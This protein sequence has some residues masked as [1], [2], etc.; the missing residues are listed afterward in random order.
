[1]LKG[2]TF[3]HMIAAL[4]LLTEYYGNRENASDC[5]GKQDFR[6]K[7]ATGEISHG[8]RH[9]T[10]RTSRVKFGDKIKL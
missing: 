4:F 8:T 10:K 2:Q 5:V 3:P 6:T 1:M 9:V 7:T